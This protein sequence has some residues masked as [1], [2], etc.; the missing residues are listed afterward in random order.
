GVG[1]ERAQ[2]AGKIWRHADARRAFSND[3]RPRTDLPALYPTRG[4]S[5]IIAGAAKVDL[6]PTT[7]AAPQRETG[8]GNVGQTFCKPYLIW[9][10]LHAIT[11]SSSESRAR[12]AS[13]GPR[14][15]DR[16]IIAPG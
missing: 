10:H 5:E 14:S 12:T 4:G 15:R 13:M 8:I 1:T 9:S 3:R 6:A 11:P 16:G 2:R 7:P